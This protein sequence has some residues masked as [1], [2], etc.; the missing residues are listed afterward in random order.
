MP[1]RW[2][3]GVD[4]IHSD[5]LDGEYDQLKKTVKAHQL[6]DGATKLPAPSR[7][8]KNQSQTTSRDASTPQK[9][10]WGR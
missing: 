1:R 8:S 4:R 10:R 3:L 5:G 9:R 2:S 7:G 6:H